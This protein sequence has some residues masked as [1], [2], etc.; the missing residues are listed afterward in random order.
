MDFK[1]KSVLGLPCG[2]YRLLPGGDE[3]GDGIKFEVR[4]EGANSFYEL[5]NE[6][7]SFTLKAT[8]TGTAA[9]PT[10]EEENID[11]ELL[12]GMTPQQGISKFI[13]AL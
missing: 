13:G 2:K 6:L 3:D 9:L 11:D 1:K 8:K 4:N 10:G 12:D 7:G 5:K